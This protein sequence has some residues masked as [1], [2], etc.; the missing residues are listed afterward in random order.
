MGTSQALSGTPSKH[1]QA[2]RAP[3]AWHVR[4]A[5][6]ARRARGSGPAPRPGRPWP[7]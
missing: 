3:L 5:A 4:S 1:A 7:P 6:S 2:Q